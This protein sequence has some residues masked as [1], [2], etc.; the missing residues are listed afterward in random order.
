MSDEKSIYPRTEIGYAFT[1][2]MNDIIIEIFDNHTFTQGSAIS[3]K[4]ILILKI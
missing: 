3:N 2:D 4:N 1:P